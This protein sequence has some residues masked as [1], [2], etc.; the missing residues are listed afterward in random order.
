VILSAESF[1]A[2]NQRRILTLLKTC[3]QLFVLDFS[4]RRFWDRCSVKGDE[5]VGF[6]TNVLSE[7]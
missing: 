4:N 2:L 6:D 1:D 3:A 5:E 7:L